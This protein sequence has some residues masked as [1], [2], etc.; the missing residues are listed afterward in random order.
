MSFLHKPCAWSVIQNML[1]Q[2]K[3]LDDINRELLL[4]LNQTIQHGRQTLSLLD[5]ELSS[6]T[7]L[8]STTGEQG[9]RRRTAI[10]WN[11]R[12]LKNHEDRIRGQIMPASRQQIASGHDNSPIMYHSQYSLPHPPDQPP[13]SAVEI[14]GRNVEEH[15]TYQEMGTNGSTHRELSVINETYYELDDDH[16]S[17][18]Q[19]SS[20]SLPSSPIFK[21]K[22]KAET[23]RKHRSASN[24]ENPLKST[25]Q[26]HRHSY[27]GR[28]AQLSSQEPEDIYH[29]Q[30]DPASDADEES[31]R[32]ATC[33]R[34]APLNAKIVMIP[35]QRMQTGAVSDKDPLFVGNPFDDHATQHEEAP[36]NHEKTTCQPPAELPEATS[37]P[38]QLESALHYA[39]QHGDVQLVHEIL[40]EDVNMHSRVQEAAN[41]DVLGP[42]AIHLAV[43][44]GQSDVALILLKHG[45]SPND[46]YHHHRR[47]LHDAAETGNQTMTAVL[48][49]HGARPNV[50]DD[51]GVEPLHIACRNGSLKVARLLIDAGASVSALDHEKYHPLHHLAQGCGD[52]YFATFLIDQGCDLEARTAQ[53]Y[54][55]LQLACISGNVHLLEV[56]LYHGA[57]PEAGERLAKPLALAIASGHMR[58][59]RYLLESGVEVNYHSPSTHETIVHLVAKDIGSRNGRSQS[60]NSNVISLLRQYGANINSQDARGD[61]PLHVAVSALSSRNR[62]SQRS[63]VNALL[64]N[65]ARADIQ[66]YDGCY[67][68]TLASRNPDFQIF[69][70][71]LAASVDRLPDKHL[72]GIDREMRREKAPAIR[73]SLKEITPLL[74]TALVARAL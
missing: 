5:N 61:T 47:P 9:F 46:Y 6:C 34:L 72:A 37:S 52:P 36:A 69:R 44:H 31:I 59:A 32:A 28:T 15:P 49:E 8:S 63:T 65:G 1:E 13:P 55:A 60:I 18:S 21:R 70:L 29:F 43:M 56:L 68:L 7:K 23:I 45:A 26:Q 51:N 17:H 41:P 40:K 12:R 33:M 57:S 58:T 19:P 67:P 54:T 10:V 30:T 73:S 3:C 66:N 50:F 48:L 62:Q 64:K 42:A 25:A 20:S 2:R 71:V 38:N 74:R 24:P 35:K 16:Y 14:S 39:C 53:G 4:Q 11:E 22:S 27:G